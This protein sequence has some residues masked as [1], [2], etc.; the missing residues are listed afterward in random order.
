MANKKPVIGVS[1]SFHDFGDYQGIGFHRP[2]VHTGGVPLILPRVEGSM[3]DLLDLCD[4]LVLAGGRD[5]DPRFYNHSPHEKLKN[6][7][8]ARDVF[9][10][11]LI[12]KALSRKI[13]ILGMCR[14]IQIL[15]V[16]LGGTM[17]QDVSLVDEWKDH[18]SDP[19]WIEWAA[20][21][22][23]SLDQTPVPPIRAIQ[24]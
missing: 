5:I 17:V 7:E 22:K 16:A 20:V 21:E 2:I 14:G 9:E 23:S 12:K 1:S 10:L 3:N 24:F 19:D 13:P 6:T 8:P 4:G 18:P 15:N 11:E